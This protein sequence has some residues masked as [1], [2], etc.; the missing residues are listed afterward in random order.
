MKDPGALQNCAK[1][2]VHIP[3]HSKDKAAQVVKT[4]T[5][6]FIQQ[7]MQANIKTAN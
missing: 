7:I 6:R 2:R 1:V 3:D 5:E 4:A